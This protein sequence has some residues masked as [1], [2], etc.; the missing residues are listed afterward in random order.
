MSCRPPTPPQRYIDKVF[1]ATTKTLDQKYGSAPALIGGTPEALTLDIYQPTGD[2]LSARPAIVWIHGGG[3]RAGGK[4]ALSDVASAY[5]Q[6]GYVTV[7]IDYRLDAE[8]RCQD[9]QDNKFPDPLELAAQAQRCAAAIEAARLDSTTALTWL[10]EH[11]ADYKIDPTR[12][13]VGG[14]SAGAVTA[15]GL[16]QKANV[17]GGEVTA[18][19]S[20]GAVLAASGC[21]FD[22]ATIDV[23][24]A[25]ISI[26][27]SGGD[28]ALPY[29]CST[30]TVDRAESVGTAVQRLFYPRES[31]HAASLYRAH[32]VDTDASW[33]TFL[34]E[35]LDLM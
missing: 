30:A 21:N 7:S 19:R 16:G 26:L 35:H 2:T 22:V 4:A 23:N 28:R 18:E 6:R 1:A 20:V 27:A 14:F 5:A 34:V 8:S 11:A 32:Q 24:D 31:A 13:A 29:A 10:R 15:L 25:P 12:I 17:D 3:F 33:T 9:V